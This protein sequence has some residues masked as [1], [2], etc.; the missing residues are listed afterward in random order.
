MGEILRTESLTKSFG[1]LRAVNDVSFSLEKGEILGLIGPNGAG[2]TTLINL[3]SGVYLPT[4][5]RVFFEG[6][7]ISQLPAH[8]VNNLGIARTFQVVRI[9]SKLTA[10]ENVLTGLVDRVGRS[11]WGFML[12]ALGSRASLVQDRKAVD[13]AD[14][15]LEFVGL[16]AYRDERAQNLPYALAKRL[17]I[18]RALATRPKL[19]LLDEPSSGLN[20]AELVGQIQLIKEINRKHATILIIEHVMKVI[21]DI[22][23]RLIVLDYGRKIAEGAPQEVYTNPMVI[24]AYLG[25]EARAG[26]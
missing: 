13:Q 7:D 6:R 21:M 3:I 19:L 11:P 9:F 4:Q 17:E 10:L 8:R 20:P 2:K 26:N 1:G 5:G 16:H 25:G 14:E 15:L 24:E 12:G 22:S 23:H 18:A